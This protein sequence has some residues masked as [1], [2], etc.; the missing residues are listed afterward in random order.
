M[1]LSEYTPEEAAEYVLKYIF[2]GRLNSGQMQ[3]L[4]HEMQDEKMWEE[5]ADLFLHE[6]FFNVGQLLYNAFNNKFPLPKALRIIIGISTKDVDDLNVFDSDTEMEVL[7]L[8]TQGMPEGTLIKRLFG[9]ELKSGQFDEA[10]DIIWQI[11]KEEAR[12]N[13]LVF[14]IISSVYWLHD[15]KYF[16]PFKGELDV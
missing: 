11:N 7:K 14:N 16:E 5:Y 6:E 10:K 12:G 15:L 2:Q 13:S 1:S 3:N 4:S 8:L 9:D